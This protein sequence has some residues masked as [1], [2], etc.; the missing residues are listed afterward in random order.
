MTC[1]RFEPEPTLTREIC[2]LCFREVTVGFHVPDEIWLAVTE[3]LYDANILCLGCFTFLADRQLIRWDAE[4][5][6]FPVSRWTHENV[7]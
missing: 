7:A 5:E 6:F 2:K 1:R 4:I 3:N